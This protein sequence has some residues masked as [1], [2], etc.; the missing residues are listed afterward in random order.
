MFSNNKLLIE[1]WK[2]FPIKVHKHCLK[3]ITLQKLFHKSWGLTPSLSLVRL[4]FLSSHN[5]L[6]TLMHPPC[7][8]RFLLPGWG[9]IDP[10]N[11][12]LYSDYLKQALVPV[13][14]YNQCRN[15]NGAIVHESSMVCVGG[16]G[17]S[18]CSG[19]SGGPLSCLEGGRWVVRGAASWVTS[20]T[21]PGDT[22]SVYARVSSY[23][24]WINGYVQS[25]WPVNQENYAVMGMKE[26]T[27]TFIPSK[28]E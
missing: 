1:Q 6:H 18:V 9:R 16:V 23:V 7:C 25:K 20:R 17:S 5:Y 24:N 26:K 12:S 8:F 2:N 22:Y 10:N 27:D 14:S 19:D 28:Y 15:I 11:L 21:C 3:I 4:D 13:V